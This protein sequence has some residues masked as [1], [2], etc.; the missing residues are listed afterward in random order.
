ME[1][2][3]VEESY[4]LAN[5]EKIE[6]DIGNNEQDGSGFAG[7][8]RLNEERL[9]AI[10]DQ[11]AAQGIQL[12]NDDLDGLRSY[13]ATEQQWQEVYRRLAESR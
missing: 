3:S 7:G 5:P 1:L 6:P 4:K 2:K 10:K 9:Q 13:L 12:T 11:M 8:D